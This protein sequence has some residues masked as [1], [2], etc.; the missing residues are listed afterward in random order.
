MGKILYKTIATLLSATMCISGFSVKAMAKETELVNTEMTEEINEEV[1]DKDISGNVS[2]DSDKASGSDAANENDTSSNDSIASDVAEM[3][4]NLD[5]EDVEE[6]D[7]IEK[8]E[9]D[10]SFGKDGK[11][12][13]E[14]KEPADNADKEQVDDV[15]LGPAKEEVIDEE[16]SEIALTAT[17]LLIEAGS[18]T[19]TASGDMPDGAALSVQEITY[20]EKAE[21]AVNEAFSES[22]KFT[23]VRAFD[24]RILVGEEEWQPVDDDTSIKITISDIGISDAGDFEEIRVY[25]IEDDEAGVTDMNAEVEGDSVTFETEHFTVYT[26]GS[27]DY[28]SDDAD[29][30]W[31]LSAKQDGSIVAYWYEGDSQLIITGSGEMLR[32]S[33]GMEDVLKE[34][35]FDVKWVDAD[36]ITSLSNFLFYDCKKMTM[37][38]LPAGIT[39]IGES[40]FGYCENMALSSLPKGLTSIGDG[41][42]KNC[43]SMKVSEFPRGVVNIGSNAFAYCLGLEAD[44][45]LSGHRIL[46]FL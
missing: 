26:V 13:S 46:G 3:V 18:Q 24:I 15:Y 22:F 23:A 42:F 27:T 1:E 5:S 7:E 33:C 25:R 10:R 2:V 9:Y 12:I 28:E 44:L 6:S 41:A 21:K 30:K 31:D 11:E 19:I 17:E 32:F 37:D 35:S 16:K 45:V 38:Y 4:E 39:R 40:A 29:I 34:K 20:M 8:Y 14:R 43:V 36:G